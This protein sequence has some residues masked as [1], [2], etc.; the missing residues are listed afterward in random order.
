MN[1]LADQVKFER[2]DPSEEGGKKRKKGVSDY[3]IGEA[4]D[5]LTEREWRL[6][7]DLYKCR[8]IPQT[9]VVDT[10]FIDS[11]EMHYEEYVT[12]GKVE[13]NKLE[14]KN[15]NRAVLKARRTFKRLKDRGLVESTSIIPDAIDLPSKRRGRVTGETWYYLSNRG[16]RIVEKRLEIPDDSKLSKVEVDMER[17]KKDHY[18]ELGKIY[19]DLRYQWMARFNDLRQFIDW[20]W[21][22]SEIVWGDNRVIEV[23]PDAIL[24]IGEQ[25]FCIELDRSTEPI[26]R[27]PFY[28]E[29]VSIQKKLERY[30]DV[31]KASTNP[32]IRNSII[33]FVIPDAVYRTRLQNIGNAADKVFGKK[34]RVLIGRKIEDILIAYSDLAGTSHYN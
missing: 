12:A 21:Y 2:I 28:T 32:I 10:Y 24:R 29:Q 11:P 16:L 27:S 18:W 23:R 25:L 6:L 1:E 31:I 33:A 20:D 22:P 9:E 3:S 30:R 7:I 13:K 19:L 26:Q 15:R 5:L 17:A 4:I 14:E 8:C 34:H